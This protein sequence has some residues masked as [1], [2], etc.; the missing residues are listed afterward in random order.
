MERCI[1]S[2]ICAKTSG[3]MKWT[4]RRYIVTLAILALTVWMTVI[5]RTD[6]TQEVAFSNG[7]R[8]ILH[9]ARY[10]RENRFYFNRAR[11]IIF[12]EI[13]LNTAW[14]ALVGRFAANSDSVREIESNYACWQ[15]ASPAVVVFA[16]VE[17]TDAQNRFWEFRAVAPSGEEG[18]TL[19]CKVLDRVLEGRMSKSFRGVVAVGT[20]LTNAPIAVRVYEVAGPTSERRKL[21]EIHVDRCR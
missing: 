7:S 4:R 12:D 18:P 2:P 3:A 11:R 8:F 13:H 5:W 19:E 20:D 14:Q 1:G 15:T 17:M 21:A 10:G 6:K 16:D 9:A